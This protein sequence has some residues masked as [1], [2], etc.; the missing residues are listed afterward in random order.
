[1]RPNLRRPAPLSPSLGPGFIGTYKRLILGHNS[2]FIAFHSGLLQSG[3]GGCFGFLL[4]RGQCPSVRLRPAAISLH[5]ANGCPDLRC[6]PK[7][8]ATRP[9]FEPNT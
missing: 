2:L 5:S 7:A 8:V 4:W 9:S 1:M 3:T 6:G